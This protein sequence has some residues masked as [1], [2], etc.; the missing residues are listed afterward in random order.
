MITTAADDLTATRVA[1]AI[2]E[3]VFSTALDALFR[4]ACG[5]WTTSAYTA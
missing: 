5:S 1:D 2:H 3:G 4:D